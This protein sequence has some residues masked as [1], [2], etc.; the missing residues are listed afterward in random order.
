[1]SNA[2]ILHIL[3]EGPTEQGF[4]NAVLKPYVMN[5]G[6]D[7]VKSV[8]VTTNRK[9]SMTGGLLSYSQA[10]QDLGIQIRSCQNKGYERHIFTTMFDLYA[11]PTDFPKYDDCR[12]IQNKYNQVEALEDAFRQDIG[13]DSFIPYIQLHEFEALVFCGIDFLPDLYPGCERQCMEL[14]RVLSSVSSPELINDSPETAPSKRIIKVID[15]KGKY[16]YNKPKTGKYITGKVGIDVLREKCP[17]FDN[18]IDRILSQ[19]K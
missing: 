2:N 4:V 10:K 6:I 18:W 19:C 16:S 17:H 3:C 13:S 15:E 1:M 5:M 12:K 7:A 11:L 14:G 8:I 9:L